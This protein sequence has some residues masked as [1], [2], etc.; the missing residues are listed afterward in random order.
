[1]RAA[2]YVGTG[3]LETI[4]VRAL[5]APRCGT[6]DALVRV[7]YAGLNRA[8][9]ADR[10]GAYGAVD[11]TRPR[12]PGLEY[13]GVVAEVGERVRHLSVG[14]R[15]MGLAPGGAHAELLAVPALTAIRVPPE[16]SLRDAGAL[17]EAFITAHDALFTRGAFALGETVAVHAVASGVGLALVQLAKHAGGFVVGT[18]RSGAKRE[19]ARAHGVDLAIPL[20]DAFAETVRAFT[21]GRGADCIVDFLGPRAFAANVDALAPGGRIVQ[22]GTL[23]GSAGA[24][25]VRGLMGKRASWIGTVLKSRG[26]DER[27]A[28]ARGFETHLAPLFARGTLHAIVDSVYPLAALAQAH[29]HM[30][31]DG[32]VGKILVEIACG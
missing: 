26:L 7:A 12:V 15:V 5:P 30:E 11:P 18:S 25:D 3:G 29:A 2:V 31:R 27:I 22:V 16:L 32:N 14:D 13:A 8:D 6:D 4:D 19:V 9:V 23:S 10:A 1:M 28:L 17:P 21:R 20:D 24:V